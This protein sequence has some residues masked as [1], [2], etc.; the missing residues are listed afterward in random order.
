MRRLSGLHGRP[1][2]SEDAPMLGMAVTLAKQVSPDMLT[3]GYR[4]RDLCK[5]LY[6]E[7][8]PAGWENEQAEQAAH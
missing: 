3:A 6:L 4:L 5:L 8:C 1:N 7:H 2:R